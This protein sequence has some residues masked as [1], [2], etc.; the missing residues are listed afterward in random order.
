M[1]E[2][3]VYTHLG[4]GDHIICNALIRGIAKRP[5]L[6]VPKALK[7]FCKD[8]HYKSVAF[9]YRDLPNVEAVPMDEDRICAFARGNPDKSLIIRFEHY[10]RRLNASEPFDKTFYDQ[11]EVDYQKKWDDFYIERDYVKEEALFQS[12]GLRQEVCIYTIRWFMR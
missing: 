1:S 12:L 2:L 9:M 3:Y 8:E 11:M 5:E 6:N 4:M 7:V 10:H